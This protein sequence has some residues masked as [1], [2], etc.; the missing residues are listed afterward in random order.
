MPGQNP[1][2]GRTPAQGGPAGR[3]GGSAPGGRGRGPDS[4]GNGGQ[5]RRCL[6]TGEEVHEEVDNIIPETPCCRRKHCL[7]SSPIGASL[8]ADG[9]KFGLPETEGQSSTLLLPKPEIK[10][11][12]MHCKLANLC[13][14]VLWYKP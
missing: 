5:R 3:F 11:G 2:G 10:K 9:R 7:H 12:F 14:E 1:G 6:E 13:P 8:P 4:A